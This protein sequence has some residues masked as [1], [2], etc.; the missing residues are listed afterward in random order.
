METVHTPTVVR[1]DKTLLALTH[2]SQLLDYVTGVGGTIVPLVLW[3]LNKDR[4]LDMDMHG[5]AILNFRISLWIYAILSIPA[6]LL[7][8]LGIITLL[9]L[10]VLGVVLPIVNAVKASNGEEPNYYIS[11]PFIS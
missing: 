7:F 4:V 9:L 11:I 2:L 10:G 5:K 1:E 3:V 6:I 8:G